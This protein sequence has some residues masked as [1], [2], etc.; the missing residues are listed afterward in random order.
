MTVKLSCTLTS[1]ISF[2]PGGEATQ[3]AWR[4]R[5]FWVGVFTGTRAVYL[6][7]ET[8]EL[9]VVLF[10][11]LCLCEIAFLI[12]ITEAHV[13]NC[14]HPSEHLSD[15]P[16]D[17]CNFRLGE[18]GFQAIRHFVARLRETGLVLSL[19]FSSSSEIMN[20]VRFIHLG[21]P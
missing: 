21:T 17:L 9:S 15:G 7:E 8:S 6:I 18:C 2:L 1:L 20:N 4:S 13:V 14:A 16:H 5:Q 19:Q 12:Y 11:F 3:Y 10:L